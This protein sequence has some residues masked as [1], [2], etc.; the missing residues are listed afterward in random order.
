MD[1]IVQI[2]GVGNVSFPDSMS[3]DQI[4]AVIKQ[5]HPDL[6][7]AAAA[8]PSFFQRIGLVPD[9]NNNGAGVGDKEME[10]G[11]GDAVIS[12]AGDV[13][14]RLGAAY[15][16]RGPGEIAGGIGDMT[17]GEI[18]K[19]GHRVM[20][21]AGIMLAPLAPEAIAA[22]PGAAALA[23][24]GGIVAGK[25]AKGISAVAGA[26][27]DQQAFIED[28][29]NF[30]GG[31]AGAKA[32][33]IAKS[34]VN[35]IKPNN[36]GE[37]VD[38]ATRGVT[39][40]I[41]GVNKFSRFRSPTVEEVLGALKKAY[42]GDAP[43]P[44]ELEPY[45][46]SPYAKSGDQLT[47]A[48]TVMPRKVLGPD[49]QLNAAPEPA[50]ATPA[51]ANP[52]ATSK[53]L[54]DAGVTQAMKDA[55]VAAPGAS[56]RPVRPGV[57]GD[58][59]PRS[60]ITFPPGLSGED[61]ANMQLTRYNINELRFMAQKRGLPV[62]PK[63]THIDLIGKLSDSLTPNEVQGFATA[64][65][66]SKPV[67]SKFTENNDMA[68][69]LNQAAAA[70]QESKGNPYEV[71]SLRSAA[72]TIANHPANIAEVDLTAN[73]IKGVDKRIGKRI[74]EFFAAQKEP[75]QAPTPLPETSAQTP[76]VPTGP[77]HMMELLR[78]SIAA[79]AGGK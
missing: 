78:Q 34:V 65:A 45:V 46:S 36:P 40:M 75:D 68:A 13:A 22:A 49:R 66:Q 17:G 74:N 24:A 28:L 51:P 16:K 29:A 47:D 69:N 38:V 41:P 20:T 73:K 12:G 27:P 15:I 11:V 79:R 26:T 7:K 62:S 70:L 77:D 60:D 53:V 48:T 64:A 71:A 19:G 54:K 57:T 76:Q 10:G 30:A 59:A 35:A 44:K 32:G 1:K 21:G 52:P 61:A 5:Q 6:T 9:P 58:L 63:D 50:A 37:L 42:A 2:D 31:Y 8:K 25:T 72:S 55:G 33:G 43:I 4:S 23:A 67:A 18:A 3:D 56:I 14:K 39:G